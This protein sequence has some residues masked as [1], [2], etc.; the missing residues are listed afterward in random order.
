LGAFGRGWSH[1]W[2]IS[3]TIA[4]DGTVNINGP[5]TAVRS[6]LPDSR[7]GYFSSPG[8][9]GKLTS[10]FGLHFLQEPN[11]LIHAFGSDGKLDYVRDANGN[12]ITCGYSGN[13]L[14]TLTHSSGQQLTIAYNA[15]G[16]IDGIT[17]QAGQH[18]TF[19]YDPAGEHLTSVVYPGGPTVAYT[20]TDAQ[21]AST[22]AALANALTSVTFPDNTHEYITY[23]NFG[24]LA[25]TSRDGGAQ[26]L[27]YSSDSTGRIFVTDA[28]TNTTTY[29]LD[30]HGTPV[31]ATDALGHS[32]YFTSDENF[33][34]TDVTDPTGK[35]ANYGYDTTGNLAQTTDAKGNATHF[36]YQGSV[37][38]LAALTDANKNTTAFTDDANGN[39]L[40]TTYANGSSE[41]WTYDST[42]NPTAW[43]NRRGQTIDFTRNSQ[44]QVTQKTY[45][46]GHTIQYAYDA[47]GLL[48][49]V[50]DSAQGTTSMGYDPRGFMT[51]ILYPNGKGFA[52]AYDN[53]GHRTGRVGTD[54]YTLSYTYDEAGRL[55]SLSNNV[56]GLLVRYTYDSVGRLAREDKGNGTFTTYTY[57]LANQILTLTNAAPDGTIQSF[58]NYTYDT[59]G[60][61]LSMTTMAGITTYAYD[62]LS[63]LT[64]VAYPGGRHVSYAYDPLGNRTTVN[65][66][67]TNMV[68]TANNL[69]Q[70]TQAGGTSFTYDADGNMTSRTDSTGTT[71]YQYDFENR[72]V[73]VTTPTNGVSQYAYDSFGNRTVVVEGGVTNSFAFDS[74]G[75]IG[76]A[77]KYSQ[78]GS[79]AARYNGGIGLLSS[80]DAAGN[81]LFFAFDGSGN[82]RHL[83]DATGIVKQAYDY[84]SFGS[85]AG[86]D[87]SIANEFRFAGKFGVSDDQDGLIFMKTRHYLSDVGRF[88][89]ADI[90]GFRGGVNVYSY[91]DNNPNAFADPSGLSPLLD[92]GVFGTV[93]DTLTGDTW[94]TVATILIPGGWGIA[95]TFY[96]GYQV[97]AP[98]AAILPEAGIGAAEA[99]GEAYPGFWVAAGGAELGGFLHSSLQDLADDHWPGGYNGAVEDV[100]DND[101][102]ILKYATLFGDLEN[103]QLGQLFATAVTDPLSLLDTDYT[104]LV[105]SFD[106]NSLTGPA[107]FSMQNYVINSGLY[108]Y[109]ITFENKT[110]ATAPAQIVQITDPLSTNLDWSTF[111]LTGIAFGDTFISVPPN[112]QHFQTTLPMSYHGVNF[113]VQIEAGINLANGQVFANFYSIDPSTGLPPSVDIGF[114]PPENGTGRGTGSVSYTV[115]P[116]ANLPEGTQITNVATIQFD[117]NPPIATDQLDDN[118]PS[119][120]IDTNKLA[121]ITIDNVPP[122]S[123]V[124]RLPAMETNVNFTVCWSGTDEG[125]GIVTY[126]IYDSAN[127][128]PWKLWRAG[129]T[130]TCET[131]NGTNGQVYA[132]YSVAHD[133][134]GNIEAKTPTAEAM[135]IT[136]G[137]SPPTIDQVAHQFVMVGQTLLVTN[138]AYSANTPITFSLADAPAGAAINATNGVFRW[139]PACV[140]GSSTNWITVRANDSGNPSLSNSTAFTVVVGECVE[141]SVGSTVMQTGTT[142]SVPVNLITSV[143]LTNLS[144][145]LAYPTNRFANWSLTGSN[146]AIGNASAINASSS[147]TFFSVST[148]SG[149]TL[150]GPALVG[151]INFSALPGPSAF[152]PL[153]LTNLAGTQSDSS[154][155]GNAF[156]QAGRVVVIGAQPLME[157]WIDTNAVRMLRVYGNPG[158]SYQI[159]S[160]TNLATTNWQEA[161]RVPLTNLFE[162]FTVNQTAPRIF[163]NSWEFFADPPILELNAPL[164]SNPTLLMY[165]LRGTNYAADQNTNLASPNAWVT[166]T[167]FVPTGSFQFIGIGSP[168][169]N[170]M[171]FRVMHP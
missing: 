9:Y 8:D 143:G 137:T 65:D 129:D 89:S 120:G 1:N 34:L 152:V 106:P 56:N 144:F 23:D 79:L 119:L 110:N 112:L 61:R 45:P 169:N 80:L 158:S 73:S 72:L 52:F 150:Q 156:G 13:Q 126:D 113:Q 46:D 77:A 128:G 145:T 127:N 43:T 62:G 78:D 67:G 140:Q 71:T 147:Q 36:A 81:I 87:R 21:T 51:N 28:L 14:V 25:S 22:N 114:L 74:P 59:K 142:S 90:L 30:Q 164:G 135:T 100:L 2:D 101:P 29:D 84:D 39:L 68:Y 123:S 97:N 124:S 162:N 19:S 132:F 93:H 48:T 134:A 139:T 131:F 55:S 149:Q 41:G 105:N 85:L 5:S 24:H 69:N 99:I 133:G 168:T 136:P 115:R 146:S 171:Y 118:D 60:N 151:A 98:I 165:G 153:A 111:Q 167:N 117:V 122:V 3:L 160:S 42:G 6:F 7:G 27:Q 82:T 91:A 64:A 18:T 12:Q 166:F 44:G 96:Y 57:D 95:K 138:H 31:I 86:S 109:Q 54:G 16:T 141:V 76:A 92:P 130:N 4:S 11:G 40:S 94:S 157:A 170:M 63:Q 88:T 70:Y 10:L 35:S 75:F 38:S 108:G 102:M 159:A 148:K 15:G 37:N 107:G 58:F 47:R 103:S 116:R 155:V 83:S 161:W 125:S 20:Y 53:A 163:Y 121:R 26:L 33:N 17:N 49:N 50:V 104:F 66:T 32:T 154:S